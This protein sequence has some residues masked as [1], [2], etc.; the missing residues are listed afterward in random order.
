M[1]GFA[2]L[3]DLPGARLVTIGAQKGQGV[4]KRHNVAR[5]FSKAQRRAASVGF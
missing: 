2:H 3:V 1:W 5:A 4:E